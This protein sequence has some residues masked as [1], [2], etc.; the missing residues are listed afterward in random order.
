VP[1]QTPWPAVTE[2]RSASRGRRMSTVSARGAM[3]CVVTACELLPE[4]GS[5]TVDYII[6]PL[7]RQLSADECTV[8]VPRD[9]GWRPRPRPRPLINEPTSS[10]NGR[11]LQAALATGPGRY[12]RFATI[13]LQVRVGAR[14][15]GDALRVVTTRSDHRPRRK[16]ESKRLNSPA[17]GGWQR[18]PETV[19][20]SEG[21]GVATVGPP[22]GVMH[23]R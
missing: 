7:G 2:S 21:L 4:A 14:P 3:T 8:P 19:G 9:D 17:G 22:R 13:R 5:R 1:S 6:G 18:Q 23:R 11:N 15:K 12:Q 16:A 20:W 10:T